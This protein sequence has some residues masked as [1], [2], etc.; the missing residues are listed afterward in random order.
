VAVH[1][2]WGRGRGS[3]KRWRSAAALTGV[4]ALGLPLLAACGSSSKTSS[5]PTT[6]SS[7]TTG[8]STSGSSGGTTGGS[9]ATGSPITIGVTLTDEGALSIGPSML[10]GIDGG[11]YYVNKMLGGIHGHP[12][13]VIMCNSDATP[14]LEVNCA[15]NF[16]SKGVVA[17]FDSYDSGFSAEDPIL[18]RANIP[19]FGVE[20][21][22]NQEDQSKTDTF[23]GPPEEAFAVG[24]LQVFH[25]E[26]DNRISLTVANAPAAVQYINEAILPVA[27]KLGMSV[28]ITYYDASSI[29][30][31]VV[32]SAELASN[33]QLTG[34][35]S[36][37][38]D[39]CISLLKALRSDGWKGPILMAG[40]SEYVQ[41]DAADAIDT[42]S[43]GDSW[44]PLLAGA[45]PPAVQT[46]IKAYNSAMAAS[47]HPN[48]N[49][50][51]QLGVMGFAGFP[52]LAYALSLGTAPYTAA[53][54]TA[55]LYKV[56]NFQSFMGPVDTCNHKEWPGTASCNKALL[57]LKVVSGDKWQ[58]VYPGGFAILN[59]SI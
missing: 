56:A 4:L 17:V 39:D 28:K 42:Y 40:C 37:T 11:L 26:G 52:D 30:W 48:T 51:G 23:F 57:M 36:L 20:S 25:N 55:D 19:V 10:P 58:S 1:L 45:A 33:P 32:A 7:G 47:G 59:P 13:K 43:Y 35:I 18:S 22:G 34:A 54:V 8:G 31:Q 24:P 38:E 14:S 49:S 6:A 3:R 15:N 41:K 29:N 2:G 9:T 21:S 27:K 12:L 50:F 53:S 16:V 46:Q 5:S 44:T